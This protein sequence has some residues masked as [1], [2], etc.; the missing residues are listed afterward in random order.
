MR[1]VI[2]TVMF[3]AKGKTM[4]YD[5][6]IPCS[7]SVCQVTENIV[8]TLNDYNPGLF[9]CSEGMKL[10]CKRLNQTLNPTETFDTIGIWNGDYII[11]GN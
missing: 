5:M 6:E 3:S 4:G 1:E 11:L 10:T 7:I 2:V 8:E 9:L